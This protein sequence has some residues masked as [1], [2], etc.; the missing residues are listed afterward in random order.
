M[1][2]ICHT[3]VPERTEGKITYQA[4][5][6]GTSHTHLPAETVIRRVHCVTTVQEIL[7]WQTL[8][9]A[10]SS[11]DLSPPLLTKGVSARGKRSSCFILYRLVPL[12]PTIYV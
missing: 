12:Y 6:P 9:L 5:S 3:A 7:Q 1:M 4:A 2:A 11:L 8:I 10:F